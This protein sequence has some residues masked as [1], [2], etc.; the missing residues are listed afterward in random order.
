MV[1]QQLRT[2][3]ND[4]LCTIRNLVYP[5]NLSSEMIGEEVNEAETTMRKV[6]LKE[7]NNLTK[8]NEEAEEEEDEDEEDKV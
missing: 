5:H 6:D 8:Y 1:R 3:G 2:I 4:L 7:E